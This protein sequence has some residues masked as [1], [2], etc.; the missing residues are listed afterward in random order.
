MSDSQVIVEDDLMSHET[1]ES[2][3]IEKDKIVPVGSDFQPHENIVCNSDFQSN[4]L[5]ILHEVDDQSSNDSSG[6]LQRW[7]I[8]LSAVGNDYIQ[9][10]VGVITCTYIIKEE[11]LSHSFCVG[12][13]IRGLVSPCL[14]NQMHS[15]ITHEVM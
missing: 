8:N 6:Y 1:V 9:E 7:D 3:P 12:C 5:L 15:D 11:S 13:P 14:Q 4:P 10:H 2:N